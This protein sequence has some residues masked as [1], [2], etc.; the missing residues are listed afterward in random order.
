MQ[1]RFR[2]VGFRAMN[3][4]LRL[5]FYAFSPPCLDLGLRV[6]E[7][8]LMFGNQGFR[9]AFF[10]PSTSIHTVPLDLTTPTPQNAKT[11]PSPR[12]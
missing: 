7:L 10:P 5:Q 4:N 1:I 3:Q 6:K 12:P 9:W 8:G 2:G 11:F